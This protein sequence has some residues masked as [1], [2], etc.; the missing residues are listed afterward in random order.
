M[1]KAYKTSYAIYCT[2]RNGNGNTS[3]GGT[4]PSYAIYLISIN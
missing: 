1:F 3:L 2:I 4:E